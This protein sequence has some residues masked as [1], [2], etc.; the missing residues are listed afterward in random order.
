MKS[1]IKIYGPPLSKAIA[2]LEKI[3]I[4]MPEVC[5]MDTVISS[6]I[7]PSVAEDV[8]GQV[9]RWDYTVSNYYFRRTGVRVPIE[10]CRSLISRSG[11]S[12]GEYDFYYEWFKR[13]SVQQVQ[14]LIERIDEALEPL[15]VMYTI[16]TK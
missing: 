14:D 9:E 1:Y 7:H 6:E 13:P 5:V 4:D 2:E 8:G 10:R 3:A 16:T 15:G 11:E 12:L